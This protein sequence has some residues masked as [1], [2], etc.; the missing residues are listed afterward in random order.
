MLVRNPYAR[1]LSGFLDKAVDIFPKDGGFAND[2]KSEYGAPYSATPPE[3][4]R[5]VGVL[6]RRRQEGKPINSHFSPQ[7][8]QCGVSDGMQYDMFLKVEDTATWYADFIALMDL[9]DTVRTGWG[10]DATPAKMVRPAPSPTVSGRV[11][12]SQ[13]S[14]L[15]N[16]RQ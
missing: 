5:F 15:A 2:M 6:L 13:Q 11:S 16:C 14:R 12:L 10:S 7:V 9:Q 3:F 4:K 1:L 8:E